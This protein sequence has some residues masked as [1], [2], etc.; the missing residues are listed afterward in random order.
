M[1]QCSTNYQVGMVPLAFDLVG[2]GLELAGDTLKNIDTH[3][4]VAL[5]SPEFRQKLDKA[6][7]EYTASVI[8]DIDAGNQ[9]NPG[10][11]QSILDTAKEAYGETLSN[12][13]KSSP[14]VVQLK[15][16]AQAFKNTFECSSTGIW[17]SENKK[18]V[19][20]VGVI[21]IVGG[22]VHM[23]KNRTGD[24]IAGLAQGLLQKT[25]KV[26]TIDLATK[27]TSLKPSKRELGLEVSANSKWNQFKTDLSIS[28]L[29]QNKS[30][31]FSTNS[32]IAIALSSDATLAFGM[33]T[34]SNNSSSTIPPI[35]GTDFSSNVNAFVNMEIKNDTTTMKFGAKLGTDEKPSYFL[36]LQMRF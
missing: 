23:Y 36:S 35:S 20:V 30:M 1:S 24:S 34:R 8:K 10:Q 6:I 27:I 31:G 17:L 14:K 13:L 16:E 26:G 28:F 18:T 12:N 22:V 2:N 29:A 7:R 3:L 9:I 32:S 25:W 4:K 5:N 11:A 33:R 21:G 15:Q 19:I